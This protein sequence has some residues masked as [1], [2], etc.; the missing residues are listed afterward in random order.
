MR[1]L[2]IIPAHNEGSI[3]EATLESICLNKPYDMFDILVVSNGSTDN[4]VDVAR[5]FAPRV[6][7]VECP[8]AAKWMAL[9]TGRTHGQGRHCIYLDADVVVSR[10]AISAT[11]ALLD[12]GVEAAAPQ[13]R[14][15]SDKPSFFVRA[16]LGIW[17]L[18]PYFA[19]GHVGAGFYAI[20]RDVADRIGPFPDIIADD[21]FVLASIDTSDR[22]TAHNEWFVHRV[23]NTLRQIVRQELRR[24][25]GRSQFE[26]YA[27]TNK[28]DL[29]SA[30][31]E[32][33]WLALL[34]RSPR[35]APAALLFLGTKL[36][37]RFGGRYLLRTGRL[38]WG[39][40]R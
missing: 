22:A 2:V 12:T 13:I 27:A 3:L 30:A 4:T 5:R 32:S 40:V 26:A 39:H 36:F 8:E 9:N 1:A 20:H 33:S 28:I 14:I 6:R 34:L 10:N 37:A 11:I 25:A 15:E 19:D 35:H 31:P 18:S 16:Y 21:Q 7:V 38:D 17:R 23:P 24:E 29:G